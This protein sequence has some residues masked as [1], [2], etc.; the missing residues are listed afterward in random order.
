MSV[1]EQGAAAPTFTHGPWEA[2]PTDY[3]DEF[4]IV[5]YATEPGL[6]VAQHVSSENIHAIAALPDLIGAAHKI[7]T[8]LDKWDGT[9]SVP[10]DYGDH[11][12]LRTALAKARAQ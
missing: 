12:A 10:I 8:A 5:S 2:V 9:G 4:D 11:E 3:E 7:F 1:S 6:A